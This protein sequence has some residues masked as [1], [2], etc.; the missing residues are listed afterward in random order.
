MTKTNWEKGVLSSIELHSEKHEQIF[1][2]DVIEAKPKVTTDFIYFH[3]KLLDLIEF[4]KDYDAKFEESLIAFEKKEKGDGASYEHPLYKFSSENKIKIETKERKIRFYPYFVIPNYSAEFYWGGKKDEQQKRSLN[5]NNFGLIDPELFLLLLLNNGTIEIEKWTENYST[6]FFNNDKKEDII[7][8]YLE[9][10]ADYSSIDILNIKKKYELNLFEYFKSYEL[11]NDAI[12]WHNADFNQHISAFYPYAEVLYHNLMFSFIGKFP[13]HMRE[14]YL[15]GIIEKGNESSKGSNITFF[16]MEYIAKN[17][18]KLLK[19]SGSYFRNINKL[20]SVRANTQRLYT[21]T[22]QGTPFNL[23]LLS[24]LRGNTTKGL[25]EK[26]FLNKWLKRFGVK[27]EMEISNAQ[28]GVGVTVTVGGRALADLGYGLTQ[29]LP[30]LLEIVIIGNR[31]NLLEDL[32]REP[33]SGYGH[34]ST[35][36]IEEPET[37]LHPKF[38]S[39]LADLF[40]DASQEYGIQFVIETHSEYLIRKLQYLTGKGELKPADTSL[41]YFYHPDEKPEGEKQVKKI[42]I[43]ENGCLSSEFGEGFFDEAD[44]LATKLFV[45]NSNTKN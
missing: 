43:Q 1:K 29:L 35:L 27:G 41:Y 36:I 10:E 37:N 3:K 9:I 15:W 4:I 28:P 40:V 45:L 8:S 22:S 12:S 24:A 42:E 34:S 23:L 44:S 39:M 25:T 6:S 14:K 16:L 5:L 11:P 13:L 30:I 19:Y 26:N 31:N 18:S 2:Y 20:D 33:N 38:Q 17:L 32:H 7:N 21:Y